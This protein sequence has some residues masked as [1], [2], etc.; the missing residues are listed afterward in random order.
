M[1]VIHHCDED[2]EFF[3]SFNGAYD[4]PMSTPFLLAAAALAIPHVH[5]TLEF[6]PDSRLPP[7]M[8]L[9][10]VGEAAAIWSPYG[11]VIES[12][13][14]VAPASGEQIH[15]AVA[16]G[17]VAGEQTSPGKLRPPAVRDRQRGEALG[18]VTF[19]AGTPVRAITVFM[20]DL[21]RLVERTRLAGTS[22]WQWPRAM[23]ERIVGRALGRVLAHEI[24]HI[25][26]QSS[27]HA[28]SGLMRSS[29]RPLDL[30][31]QGRQPFVLAT[32]AREA[33]PRNVSE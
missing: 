26:L 8:V 15:V 30:I 18:A 4:G 3:S 22:E 1:R 29:H 16:F 32:P 6:P 27:Q 17:P 24:G 31:E 10:A 21:L 7:L 14:A 13:D 25:V 28:R 20:D 19:A 5:L 33:R 11:V 23:R 12:A 9:V 2:K